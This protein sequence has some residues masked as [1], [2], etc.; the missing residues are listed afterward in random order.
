[1]TDPTPLLA[2]LPPGSSLY[3]PSLPPSTTPLAMEVR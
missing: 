3:L 2:E 1:M